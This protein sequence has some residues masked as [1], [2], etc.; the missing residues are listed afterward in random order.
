MVIII[1]YKICL[2]L[3]V[4]IS[5]SLRW[6]DGFF[7]YTRS[8]GLLCTDWIFWSHTTLLLPQ[9]QW[10]QNGWLS[11]LLLWMGYLGL[12]SCINGGMFCS[13]GCF[14]CHLCNSWYSI[15]FPCSHH[16]HSKNLAEALPYSHQEGA[17]EGNIRVLDVNVV[18]SPTKYKFIVWIEFS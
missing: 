4:H 7:P 1:I 14:R 3:S 12:L 2:L 10:P 11:E 5:F 17:Y 8:A 6:F 9:Y 18:I 15:W 16:G 13:C